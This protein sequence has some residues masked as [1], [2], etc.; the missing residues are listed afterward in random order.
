[1]NPWEALATPLDDRPGDTYRKSAKRRI[2]QERMAVP[3]RKPNPG[4]PFLAAALVA[5][6]GVARLAPVSVVDFYPKGD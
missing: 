5:T 1:V 4:E 6:N 3:Q 2:R